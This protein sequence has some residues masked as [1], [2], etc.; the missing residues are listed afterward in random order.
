MTEQEWLDCADPRDMLKHLQVERR[1]AQ[2]RGGRR[3]LRLF[4][5]ASCRHIW[6]YLA[7]ERSRKAV[8]VAERLADGSAGQA[9]VERARKEAGAAVR[10]TRSGFQTLSERKPMLHFRNL[11]ATKAA[12]AALD[13]AAY[14]A[15]CRACS[16]CVAV[17]GYAVARGFSALGFEQGTKL[18]M[19]AQGALL[20][21]LFGNPFRPVALDRTCLTWQGSTIPKLALAIYQERAFDRLPILADA[22]ED[23]GCDNADILDHCRGPA[24]H[25]RG[26]WVLDQL[27]EKQ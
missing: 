18:E 25:A 6:K 14:P 9:E 1:L 17:A 2:S 3:K 13:R 21:D 20:R 8:E 23:A 16:A 4:A 12:E 22:L 24:P 19:A 11:D 7:D 5:C 15:A 27:T 26:C 10:A